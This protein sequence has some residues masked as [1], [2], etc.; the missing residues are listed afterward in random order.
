MALGASNQIGVTLAR[1]LL[2]KSGVQQH[3]T[4]PMV[5]HRCIG[6][7]RRNA[8]DIRA[9]GCQDGSPPPRTSVV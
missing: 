9:G 7:A 4:P 6:W 2:D 5:S 1:Q 3:V 8:T